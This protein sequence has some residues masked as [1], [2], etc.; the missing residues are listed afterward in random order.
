M[1]ILLDEVR[2]RFYGGTLFKFKLVEK[3]VWRCTSHEHWLIPQ[4]ILTEIKREW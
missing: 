4:D 1:A 2:T 3:G